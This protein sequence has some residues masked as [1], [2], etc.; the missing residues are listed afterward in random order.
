MINQY[1]HAKAQLITEV[2]SVA[3]DLKKMEMSDVSF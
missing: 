3:M 1:Y 2:I